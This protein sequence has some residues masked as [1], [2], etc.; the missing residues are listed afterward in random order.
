MTRYIVRRLFE[1]VVL[2]LL[3]SFIL[4]ALAYSFGDPISVLTDG[5]APPTGEEAD[6]LRRALGLD[7][8]LLT[9][10]VYWLIGNDW[11]RIDADGDGDTDENV[12][13]Q[14]RGILRGDLGQSLITR[15][16]TAERIAERLPVSLLLLVPSYLL[17][18]LIALAIGL[19]AALRP[20]SRLDTALTTAALVGYA[21]PI[22]FVCLALI[23]VFAV[24]FRRWGLPH[25]PIA[26]MYDL[27]QP[28]T[29]DNL[30]RHLVL[31]IASLTIV[32][33][34]GYVRF[35][36]SGILDVLGQDY[37]RN[38]RA[39]GLPERR[40]IGLH[41]LKPAALPLVTLVGLDLPALLG[42]AVVTE[43][44]FA[45]P[46]MGLLFLNSLNAGDFPVVMGI[47]ILISTA[48]I[49]FQLLTDIVY[50]LLDP[51]VTFDG[52]GR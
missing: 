47:L 35:V 18:L 2:L 9:Q 48:V 13:G 27:S 5:S 32:Q 28:R 51:R 39:K 30:L 21:L 14:R 36:R 41:V 49:G 42:G 44:I 10:Y 38:A 20:H 15:Q 52:G 24:Q 16:P 4:F 26:G 40:V 19:V 8:P 11:A 33:L 6:R 12:Y 23:Y 34:A 1:G 7:Q 46:G 3:V 17:V 31:P 50:T 43:S 29:L 45:F 25:L 37:I 22:F